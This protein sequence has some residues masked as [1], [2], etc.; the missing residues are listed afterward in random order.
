MAFNID[1]NKLED[2]FRHK[3]YGLESFYDSVEDMMDGDIK[4]VFPITEQLLD[5]AGHY[6]DESLLAEGGEKKIFRVRDSK[7]GREKSITFRMHIRK[8]FRRESRVSPFSEAHCHQYQT[9]KQRP[10]TPKSKP[11]SFQIVVRILSFSAAW[12]HAKSSYDLNLCRRREDCNFPTKTSKICVA[13]VWLISLDVQT[14]LISI[15]E[16]FPNPTA[17]LC[18]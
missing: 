18:I 17:V 4:D 6:D 2:D 12:K 3:N 9:K 13:K 11:E 8:H 5:E 14:K 1:I 15:C 16:L 7:A 10:K